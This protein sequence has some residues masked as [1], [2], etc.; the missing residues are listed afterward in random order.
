MDDYKSSLVRD[1]EWWKR[2]KLEILAMILGFFLQA[3]FNTYTLEHDKY[4]TKI[5]NKTEKRKEKTFLAF[6]SA[7]PHLQ[8]SNQLSNQSSL[9]KNN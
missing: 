9:A 6:S 3:F 5:T 7:L 8:R 2:N 4:L 1:R